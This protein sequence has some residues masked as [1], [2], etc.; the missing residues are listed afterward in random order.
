MSKNF[1]RIP[2]AVTLEGS[3]L[4]E[5]Q[6]GESLETLDAEELE[7]RALETFDDDYDAFYERAEITDVEAN[8][9]AARYDDDDYDYD[10]D[11]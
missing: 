9:Y 8:G 4:I 7:R 1:V 5:L 6:D 2:I 10:G 11:W 3:V